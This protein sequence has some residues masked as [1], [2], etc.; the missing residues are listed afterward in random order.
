MKKAALILLL[1]ALTVIA[2]SPVRAQDGEMTCP[3]HGGTTIASL[4]ECVTHAGHEGHITNHGIARSLLAKLD[5]AQRAVDRG[6]DET[7]VNVLN[8]F[9]NEVQAQ[10]GKHIHAEHAMHLIEHARRV[11]AALGG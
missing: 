8:S 6:Q 10:A 5:A 3:G 7:A 11:I 1:M 2:V 9:I 4:R